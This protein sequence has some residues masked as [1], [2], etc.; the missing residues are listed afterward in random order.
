MKMKFDI[1][2]IIPYI[3]IFVL[4][5]A[6]FLVLFTL[7]SL[8][9]KEAIESNVKQSASQLK[10]EVYYADGKLL[11][12]LGYKYEILFPFTDAIMINEAYSI[13]PADP[14]FSPLRALKDYDG[15]GTQ[16]IGSFDDGG[17]SKFIIDGNL[18]NGFKQ[19]GELNSFVNGED[20][21]PSAYDYSRYWHGYLIWLR[22]ALT[23]FDYN[24]LRIVA[25]VVTA[26]LVFL[27]SYLLGK[28]T[29]PIYGLFFL[30]SLLTV[31]IF[32]TAFSLNEIGDFILGLL[33]M[34]IAIINYEEL[35]DHQYKLFFIIGGLTSFFDLLTCPLI[36]FAFPYIAF[37][38]LEH[39]NSDI[40]TKKI[41]LEAVKL[42]AIWFIGFASIWAF[43]WILASIALGKNIIADALNQVGTRTVTDGVTT[44][45]QKRGLFVS[46]GNNLRQFSP[47]MIG[48]CCLLY[49]AE[50]FALFI[51]SIY[52]KFKFDFKNNILRALPYLFVVALPFI[53]Y[54]VL[55]EHS[56]IHYF[57][58]YRYM[59]IA[60][61]GI[62]I[63]IA[64]IFEIKDPEKQTYNKDV[65]NNNFEKKEQY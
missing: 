49:V 5:I 42:I 33:F 20:E 10:D 25:L 3:I 65:T 46:I 13:D 34:V 31:N 23:L 40:T 39:K 12:D 11:F 30:L 61:F 47:T 18:N 35:L 32:I 6:S 22:P 52:F 24:V 37:L 19:I 56:Y 36:T 9:P 62:F 38:L 53:W 57:F 58:T 15:S 1:K 59:C 44:V 17:N 41:L 7:S 4:M 50:I 55:F 64:K 26:I 54:M 2:K 29:K 48:I 60:A 51:N 28:Y 21:F 16:K 27:A 43:K 63:F 8:I 45:A 14:F